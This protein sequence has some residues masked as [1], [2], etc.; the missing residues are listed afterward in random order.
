MLRTPNVW[1]ESAG[2][3]PSKINCGDYGW[4]TI[5][6]IASHTGLTKSGVFRRLRH[7][8]EF[9]AEVLMAP[10]T[11]SKKSDKPLRVKPKRPEPIYDGEDPYLEGVAAHPDTSCPYK[12]ESLPISHD[13]RTQSP[14]FKYGQWWAGWHDAD[15]DLV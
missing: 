1:Q 6:Q 14:M 15:M 9:N 5:K 3:R 2:T 13:D 10:T 11:L 7:M 8:D 4:L 12:P